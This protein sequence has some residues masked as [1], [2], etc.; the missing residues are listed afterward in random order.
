M[1]SPQFEIRPSVIRG[2][3]A[4]EYLHWTK[5][6]LRLESKN[7]K[8]LMEFYASKGGV[9]CGIDEAKS[10]L[11]SVLPKVDDE[12][13][14]NVDNLGD[15]V[16][17]WT[18]SEGDTFK[19]GDTILRIISRYASFGLYETSIC[20]ILASSTGWATAANE[21]VKAAGD[22]T[23]IAYGARHIHPNVAHIMDYSSIVGGCSSASTR[24]GS[25]QAGRNAFGNMPH[26]LPLIF[27]DTVSAAQAFDHRMDMAV[28]RIVLVDTFRDEVEESL[29]VARALREKLRGV[30]LDTPKER[31]GVTPM[32]VNEVR[33][34]LDQS[35]FRHVEIYV[36]GGFNPTR[37]RQ[38][39]EEQV[40][41]N[42]FMV[43]SYITSAPPIDFTADIREISD[44]P[45]SKRG[46]LPGRVDNPGLERVI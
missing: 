38:F 44:N 6:I 31:G 14:A 15:D 39:V 33:T 23:V 30:R 36:S 3:P 5:E 29:G 12:A 18:V 4:D 45:V 11:T 19:A 41:V 8:V 34:R 43:G 27:G 21:C 17:V 37:I 25:K 35:N 40:P 1:T 42:G 20:G 7:P 2:D 16:Q 22:T 46:R 13:I 24:L 9:I 28:Q 10:L 32:M 26:T